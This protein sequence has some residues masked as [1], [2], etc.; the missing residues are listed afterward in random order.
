MLA[1]SLSASVLGSAPQLGA[2]SWIKAFGSE[3]RSD[4]LFAAVAAGSASAKKG[5]NVLHVNLVNA[6]QMDC[7]DITLIG[8][9][10]GQV[11]P[12]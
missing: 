8:H 11:P 4:L 5:L 3:A 7:R 10:C 1:A 2:C 9:K 12:I 6:Q